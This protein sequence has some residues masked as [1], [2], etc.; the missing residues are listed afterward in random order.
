MRFAG[1]VGLPP[2]PENPNLVVAE[3]WSGPLTSITSSVSRLQVNLRNY[4]TRT[5]LL[6]S[7]E[8]HLLLEERHRCMLAWLL[9]SS[10]RDWYNSLRPAAQ[11]CYT[12]LVSYLRNH[13]RIYTRDGPFL[14][15]DYLV[16]II[17]PSSPLLSE[18]SKQREWANVLV[19]FFTACMESGR[20]TRMDGSATFILV[21]LLQLYSLGD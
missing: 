8:A 5:R 9:D 16:R 14:T 11:G 4:I 7:H 20:N 12:Y 19:P 6:I 10:V 18:L 15:L 17:S 1:P 21:D 13:L 3:Q 2:C